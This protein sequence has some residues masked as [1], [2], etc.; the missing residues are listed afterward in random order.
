MTTSRN[1][2]YAHLLEVLDG[3][4]RAFGPDRTAT[5]GSYYLDGTDGVNKV[6]L[7]TG[8]I[9]PNPVITPGV[10]PGSRVVVVWMQNGHDV[11]LLPV[12]T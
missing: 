4:A 2:P 3:R 12:A 1:D 8:Q 6:L 11:F 9:I 5:H 10:K 7:D